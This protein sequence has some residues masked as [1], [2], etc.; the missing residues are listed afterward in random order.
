VTPVSEEEFEELLDGGF[1]RE[2]A[3]LE[4]RDAYGTAVELPHMAQWAAGEPDDLQWLQG[5]CA[6]LRGHV[7]AG[8]SVRRARV[9]SEP[10]SDYQRWSHSIALPMVDAGE[11]VRWVPRRLVSA[12]ALPGNDFYL[13]DDRLAVFLL[14]AGNGLAAGK[15]SSDDPAVLQLCRSSFEAAWTLS[16]PH[17][18]YAAI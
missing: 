17:R 14:Y 16:V 9:V 18:E 4:M 7:A 15:V 6:V 2:A 11:D 1:G 8:R 10:L 13:F 12:V 3:H 5:W